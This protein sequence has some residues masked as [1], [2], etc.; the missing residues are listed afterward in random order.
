[1]LEQ[2]QVRINRVKISKVSYPVKPGDI[3]TLALPSQVKVIR[4]VAETERRGPASIARQLYVDLS[5]KTD[6]TSGPAC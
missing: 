4:V 3:L 2:G 1:M 5:E 6:A